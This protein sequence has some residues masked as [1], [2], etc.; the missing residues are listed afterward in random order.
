MSGEEEG[1]LGCGML[2][3]E[4]GNTMLQVED[5]KKTSTGPYRSC[6]AV[7]DITNLLGLFRT[8]LVK[9]G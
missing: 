9:F 5:L 6:A 8:G 1:E 2:D 3:L 7:L 4:T